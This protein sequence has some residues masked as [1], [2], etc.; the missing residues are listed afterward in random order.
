MGQLVQKHLMLVVFGAIGGVFLLVG[1]IFLGVGVSSQREAGHLAE[2]PV[3]DLADLGQAAAG[4][5]VALEGKISERNPFELRPFVAYLSQRYDGE[6]CRDEPN[7]DDNRL[8]CESIWTQTER[9]TPP[10]WLDLPG[11]RVRLTNTDY[12][13]HYPP[14]TQQ[15]TT[16]LIKN[17]TKSYQ[18]FRIGDPV[19]AIGQVVSEAEGPALRARIVAG[20]NQQSYLANT[21]SEANLFTW[22]GGLFAVGGGVLIVVPFIAKLLGIGTRGRRD[23]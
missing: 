8:E 7:D 23:G 15:S 11:G 21:R 22:L 13:I 5:E 19:F 16:E 2:V 4:I 3:L 6:R 10:L 18:G 9:V 1:L 17:E 14:F 12:Q 20:G